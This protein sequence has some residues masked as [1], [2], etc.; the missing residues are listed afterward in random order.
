MRYFII[1]YFLF[2]VLY[3]AD[4]NTQIY[5]D[6]R[7]GNVYVYLNGRLVKTQSLLAEDYRE[8]VIGNTLD[9]FLNL[10]ELKANEDKS[11]PIPVKIAGFKHVNQIGGTCNEASYREWAV[12]F[13]GDLLAECPP[14][15]DV[16][17]FNTAV[18]QDTFNVSHENTLAKA[19]IGRD[20][21]VSYSG[22][23]DKSKNRAN[24]E[25]LIKWLKKYMRIDVLYHQHLNYLPIIERLEQGQPLPTARYSRR[26]VLKRGAYTHMITKQLLLGNGIVAYCDLKGGGGHALNLF[27]TDGNQVYVSTWGSVYKGDFPEFGNFEFFDHA[28]VLIPRR[29]TDG[30]V[31]LDL[32]THIGGR[33]AAEALPVVISEEVNGPGNIFPLVTL[34]ELKKNPEK[35]KNKQIYLYANMT[36]LAIAGFRIKYR[37]ADSSRGRFYSQ[38]RLL[39]GFKKKVVAELPGKNE[40]SIN[41]ERKY[42]LRGV[43][44]YNPQAHPTFALQTEFINCVIL[45]VNL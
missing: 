45:D 39:E 38:E 42:V 13:A 18:M 21:R 15:K 30:S 20:G 24:G 41:K 6:S 32:E 1:F 33:G 35:F 23:I 26:K 4:S 43:L 17:L 2:T 5:V 22:S 16:G 37:V 3:G 10:P 14:L 7:K 9:Q 8:A 27:G 29:A 12:Y 40:D 11:L 31:I 28:S 36:E 25:E 34:A 19:K 44:R